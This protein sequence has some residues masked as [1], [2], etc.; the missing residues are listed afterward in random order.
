MIPALR[1]NFNRYY[2]REKYNNLLVALDQASGT[3]IGFRVSETPCFVPHALIDQMA[4][5]VRRTR[6]L[7]ADMP[8]TRLAA[9]P[10]VSP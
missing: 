6:E 8:P 3:R 5:D 4:R 2:T 7:V 9:A 1:E 10:P